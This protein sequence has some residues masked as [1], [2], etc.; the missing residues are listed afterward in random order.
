MQWGL[1]S[2]LY[3]SPENLIRK[4]VHHIISIISNIFKSLQP[5]PHRPVSHLFLSASANTSWIISTDRRSRVRSSLK[6]QARLICSVT[7]GITLL[8]ISLATSVTIASAMFSLVR[9]QVKIRNK[10]EVFGNYRG[11]RIVK[12]NSKNIYIEVRNIHLHRLLR[13]RAS[14]PSLIKRMFGSTEPT[15]AFHKLRFCSFFFFFFFARF[16]VTRLL[17]MFIKQ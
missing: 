15:S 9:T 6:P 1:I 2:D 7:S 11:N 14:A 17:F 8:S 3:L 13:E 10:Q 4:L 16:G 5:A 12:T